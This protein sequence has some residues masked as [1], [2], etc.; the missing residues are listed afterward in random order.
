M[1]GGGMTPAPRSGRAPPAPAVRGTLALALRASAVPAGVS[2]AQT[3]SDRPAPQ[4]GGRLS[5]V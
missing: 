2:G 5:G 3:T 4:W 1:M